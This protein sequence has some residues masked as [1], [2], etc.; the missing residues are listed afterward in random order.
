MTYK[1]EEE[2]DNENESPKPFA[3]YE[4]PTGQRVHHFYISE[5]VDE[6][7]KYVD[8][9]HRI[10]TAGPNDLI[11]I[12]LNTPGGRIDT[13]LQIISA[14]K[15]SP[16][17]VVTVMEGEV[18][19]LGTLIFLSGDEFIVH[20]HCMFMIHNYSG[21]TYGKGHEQVAQLE[22]MTREWGKL[23]SDVYIPFLSED[24]L[25][26]VIQGQDLWMGS[27]EVRDRL[28]KMIKIMEKEA[29]DKEKA[30]KQAAAK[31]RR[32]KTA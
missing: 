28:Q 14:M 5:G 7:A 19:S 31:P 26:R 10:K 21:G 29:K 12:Y 6:P 30:E 32:R 2:K 3:Y 17:H 15:S 4:S 16:A 22:A 25:E 13:G 1:N 27:E 11:Y 18:C 8:M 9:I 23:A 20:D 24:E